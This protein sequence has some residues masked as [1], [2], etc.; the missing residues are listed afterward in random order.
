LDCSQ[1]ASGVENYPED[2]SLS[3]RIGLLTD[4][5]GL[6]LEGSRASMIEKLLDDAGDIAWVDLNSDI[7]ARHNVPRASKEGIGNGRIL[8]Q[9]IA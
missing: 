8:L 5:G 3:G 1:V 9:I 2:L 4:L 6:T 7:H